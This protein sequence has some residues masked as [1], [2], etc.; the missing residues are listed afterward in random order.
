MSLG[1]HYEILLRNDCLQTDE[2][3]LSLLHR[4][5]G[6]DS[7]KKTPSKHS[8]VKPNISKILFT[9]LFTILFI[10]LFIILFT[11]QYNSC[12]HSNYIALCFNPSLFFR[13]WWEQPALYV[14]WQ[15]LISSQNAAQASQ[16]RLVN[17]KPDC[18]R[19]W[20]LFK[21]F[22]WIL[23]YVPHG[24]FSYTY[25]YK[26]FPCVFLSTLLQDISL[27]FPL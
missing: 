6:K 17:Q 20:Q 18:F 9:I 1:N 24:A 4:V 25:S 23:E 14:Q 8:Y 12:E 26:I 19:K 7:Y 22:C 10:I 16:P 21:C 11:I 13:N 5:R 27:C 15:L 2:P 3:H